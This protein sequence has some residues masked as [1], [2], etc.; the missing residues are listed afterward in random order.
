M[1]ERYFDEQLFVQIHSIDLNIHKVF[2]ANRHYAFHD[3]K[4][5]LIKA[6]QG[7]GGVEDW[8]LDFHHRFLLGNTI[9]LNIAGG[10]GLL[11]IVLVFTGLFLWWPYRRFWKPTIRFSVK[12]SHARNSHSNLGAFLAGPLLLI[13]VTGVIL[14]YPTE[15]RWLLQNGFSSSAPEPV[16]IEKS[17]SIADLDAQI[18]FALAEFPGSRLRSLQAATKG[19]AERVIGLSQHGAWDTTGKTSVRFE[20]DKVIIK[21]ARQQATKVRAVGLTYA[22]HIGKINLAYRLALILIGICLCG[23]TFFGFRSFYLRRYL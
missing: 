23:L 13:A 21:D 16:I 3:S 7:N 8:L 18:D 19:K 11:T 1:E 17:L 4:G 10:S 9:G 15:S 5:E 14:V 20:S 22:L 2:L 12:H 6:W